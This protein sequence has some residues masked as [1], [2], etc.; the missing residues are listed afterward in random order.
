MC[1]LKDEKSYQ[2]I[3]TSY[4]LPDLWMYM[5]LDKHPVF[6]SVIRVH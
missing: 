6:Q 4:I 3:F 1:L 5:N 2:A